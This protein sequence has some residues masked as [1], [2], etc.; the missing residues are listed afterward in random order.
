MNK[1]LVISTLPPNDAETHSFIFE[2]NAQHTDLLILHTEHYGI[3]HCIGCTHCWLKTPGICSIKD[4]YEQIFKSFLKADTV[5]LLTE[6]KLGFISY[7]MKNIVDRLL[8]MAVPYT[9][10]YNGEARHVGRYKK[11]WNIGLVY[12]G[13]GDKLYLNEWMGRFALNFHSKSLGA[14]HIEESEAILHEISHIQLLSAPGEK[15]QHGSN[16]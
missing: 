12:S 15:Q 5:I 14:Y 2:I 6:A 13:D 9:R 8:P 3:S 11:G 1:I 10:F 7:K 16:C 4:G